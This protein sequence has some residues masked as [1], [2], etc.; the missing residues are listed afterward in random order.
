MGFIMRAAIILAT[1]ALLIAAGVYLA[2]GGAKPLFDAATTKQNIENLARKIP[3]LETSLKDISQLKP[4][5]ETIS[6][7]SGDSVTVILNN[8]PGIRI[9]QHPPVTGTPSTNV[10]HFLVTQTEDKDS[11]AK[12]QAEKFS[13]TLTPQDQDLLYQEH[14][15]QVEVCQLQEMVTLKQ[16]IRQHG[17]A[18]IHVLQETLEGANHYSQN[19]ELLKEKEKEVI[20]QLREELA[21]VRELAN[22]LAGEELSKANKTENSLR[23]ELEKHEQQM[24]NLGPAGRLYAKGEALTIIPLKAEKIPWNN[25]HATVVFLTDANPEKNRTLFSRLPQGAGYWVVALKKS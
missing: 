7:A 14:Q 16:L 1:V 2:L 17:L 3:A 18:T 5:P 12:K 8:L 19:L 20:P 25:L 22:G 21:E 10:V 15:L 9:I 11:F 13:N 24:Q 6:S 4:S 23:M